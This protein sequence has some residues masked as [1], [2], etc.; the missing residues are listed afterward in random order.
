M[1][2]ESNTIKYA[3]AGVGALAIVGG[4]YYMYVASGSET[5]K[6]E[7]KAEP[8]TYEQLIE[9]MKAEISKD[10]D[11]PKMDGAKLSE[12]YVLSVYRIL[13]KYTTLFKINEDDSN[14][15]DRIKLLKEDKNEEYEKTRREQDAEQAKKMQEIQDLVFAEYGSSTQEYM[16]GYQSHAFKPEFAAKTQKIQNEIVTQVQG[17]DEEREPPAGLTKEL[18]EEIRDFAKVETQ[19]VLMQLQSTVTDQYQFQEKFMFEVSK[20]D[21]VIFVKYGFKNTDV[22]KAFQFYKLIPNQE[23]NQTA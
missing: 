18:A 15:G 21:D 12:E 23:G 3:L 10:K 5:S 6:E 16:T 1:E 2:K 9:N 11:L 4:L 17:T 19:K 14:F 20:L 7:A 8:L 13:T 22:L